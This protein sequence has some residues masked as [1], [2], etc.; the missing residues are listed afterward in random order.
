MQ[1]VRPVAVGRLQRMTEGVA[2]VQ[3]LA[4]AGL[5]FVFH[6]DRR[7][8]GAGARDSI[9]RR[10]RLEP[11]DLTAVYG[12]PV[13]ERRIIDQAVFQ[14]FRIARLHFPHRQCREE[15]GIGDHEHR[16]VEGADQILAARR[17]HG[18]L[19][20]YGGIDLRQQCRRHL[21]KT[22]AALH[23]AGG[24]AAHVADD[25]AAERDQHVAPVGAAP[26]QPVEH[27]AELR[28]GLRL[29]ARRQGHPVE[30]DPGPGHRRFQPCLMMAHHV[31]V[32]Q[33]EGARTLHQEREA[34][35]QIC[36]GARAHENVIG[37]RAEVYPDSFNGR[38]GGHVGV[39][40]SRAFRIAFTALVWG[41]SLD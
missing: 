30:P 37:A 18:C 3:K 1:Q 2:E 28:E 13:K 7:F 27:M 23:Q 39:Q 40:V 5:G 22:H 9:A 32:R 15:F 20:A 29:L 38:G 16:L 8:R 25:A 24:K 36:Q 41:P 26:Q 17:I 12:Q 34:R 4:H 11:Q 10:F 14:D 6:D 31:F 21:Y 35:A 19:S 33:H